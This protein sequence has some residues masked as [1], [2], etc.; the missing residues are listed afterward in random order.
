VLLAAGLGWEQPL[1]TDEQGEPLMLHRYSM[2]ARFRIGRLVAVSA[3]F[4]FVKGDWSEI[5]R[6]ETD[7][8]FPYSFSRSTLLL[9]V[10]FYPLGSAD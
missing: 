1:Y 7:R 3:A 5:G 2:G 4:R 10:D 6:F 9:G 8:R